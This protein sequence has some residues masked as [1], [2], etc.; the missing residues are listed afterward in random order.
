M[1]LCEDAMGTRIANVPE[2]H[3]EEAALLAGLSS[4]APLASEDHADDRKISCGKLGVGPFAA[5]PTAAGG[6]TAAFLAT[7]VAPTG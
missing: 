3:A 4:D 1:R 5:N 7:D 2:Q 6:T